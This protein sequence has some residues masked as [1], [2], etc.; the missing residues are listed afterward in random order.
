[1]PIQTSAYGAGFPMTNHGPSVVHHGGGHTLRASLLKRRAH[2]RL[3]PRCRIRHGHSRGKR[4]GCRLGASAAVYCHGLR[5]AAGIAVVPREDRL[6]RPRLLPVYVQALGPHL[7]ACD[8]LLDEMSHA[9]SPHLCRHRRRPLLLEIKDNF[10]VFI[11][12]AMLGL[13]MRLQTFSCGEV[14]R[15]TQ[16][17]REGRQS[18]RP[19]IEY[20]QAF[21]LVVGRRVERLLSHRCSQRPL[22][23]CLPQPTTKH[24]RCIETLIR[25]G[26]AR[27]IHPR[28]RLP[29][30][31]HSPFLSLPNALSSLLCAQGRMMMAR[32][33]NSMCQLRYRG[34]TMLLAEQRFAFPG[35]PALREDR[36]ACI[37]DPNPGLAK[38]NVQLTIR[39]VIEEK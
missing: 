30:P 27:C 5:P 29:L 4:L 1:M 39:A 36:R 26:H 25:K 6:L 18:Q 24:L 10:P 34:P 35:M 17:T 32:V 37:Y 9:Q 21:V 38:T 31:H 14:G 15:A 7:T 11:P 2:L 28:A 20:A 22:G 23:C 13:T 19:R 12:A 16:S 8:K 3:R 33:P